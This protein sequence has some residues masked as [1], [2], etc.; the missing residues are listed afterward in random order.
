MFFIGPLIDYGSLLHHMTDKSY[1]MKLEAVRNQ[2]LRL[3]LRT[4]CTCP[5]ASHQVKANETPE[6]LA[7]EKLA[8]QYA[9]KI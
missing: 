6:H 2:A 8:Q 9:L 3:Y 1:L 7:G 5:I 4:Y